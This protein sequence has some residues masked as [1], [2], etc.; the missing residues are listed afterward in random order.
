[1]AGVPV[2]M[3]EVEKQ[4]QNFVV[5]SGTE[6]TLTPLMDYVSSSMISQPPPQFHASSY[7]V[8]A[9]STNTSMMGSLELPAINSHY[10][11]NH[12][13]MAPFAMSFY[14]QEQE[15]QMMDQGFIVGAGLGNG[16]SSIVSHQDAEA[17]LS[18]NYQ[19]N[20]AAADI[21]SMDMGMDGM[22]KY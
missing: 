20:T 5:D 19:S 4:Q 7:Q 2:S 6:C 14:H 21:L 12:Q 11:G 18:T 17:R 3:G 10:F 15:M 16:P 8:N 22:W 13:M 1:M 9:F